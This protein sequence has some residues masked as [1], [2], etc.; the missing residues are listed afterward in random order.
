MSHKQDDTSPDERHS[1]E[2]LYARPGFIIRRA[3]QIV[4]A[5]FDEAAAELGITT[6]QYSVL[7]ALRVRP[8]ID[9]ISLCELIGIDRSTA[10]LVLRLL[11]TNG[12]IERKADP[13]DGRRKQ[14][15]LSPAGFRMLQRA[16][17]ATTIISG[18]MRTV[19][20]DG[21]YGLL[22]DL[23]GKFVAAYNRRVRNPLIPGSAEGE[24]RPG[25]KKRRK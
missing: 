21:E 18:H 2:A 16:E 11:E 13:E 10:T 3:H 4:A 23:L 19:L 9:Q 17:P 22:I 1:L 15:T 25:T 5:L 20:S 14:L 24:Q 12:L 7:Y 6:T 8:A